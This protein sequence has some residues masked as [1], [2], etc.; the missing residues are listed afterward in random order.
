MAAKSKKRLS[1]IENKLLK[2]NK[3]QLNDVL[4]PICQSILIEPVTLPCYHDFCKTC[5]NGS[6]E[7]NAL[8][9]PLCRLRIGSW[10]RIAAKQKTVVNLQL[11]EF[12]RNK[13]DKEVETKLR[14]EDLNLSD[15]MG[16]MCIFIIEFQT[17]H[18]P[19]SD[20]SEVNNIY[21]ASPISFI[22]LYIITYTRQM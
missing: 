21:L 6:V 14:G 10:L 5:F 19:L 3:L 4:C 15:G 17:I 7:N 11:W 18:R 9:C 22:D 12:I 1:K 16:C 2:L 13:F 20:Q 8:C